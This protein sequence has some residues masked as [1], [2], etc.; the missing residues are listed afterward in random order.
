VSW[1]SAFG[2]NLNR[3]PI[4]SNRAPDTRRFCACWGK[5]AKGGV[6]RNALMRLFVAIDIDPVIR[7]RL[8]RFR[9]EMKPL[10]PQARWVGVETFHVTM[11]FIGEQSPQQMEN[12]QS[13]LS[14]I[15]AQ[16]VAIAFRNTGF[17]PAA[18]SA[19]VFWVGIE[20]D[21]NLALLAGHVDQALAALRIPREDRPFTP[22]LTLARGGSGR[23]QR[24]PADRPN[25]MF[26]SL[27]QRLSTTAPP[28]FGAMT[29][30][31]F[32]LYESKLS[33]AGAQY[34]KLARFPLG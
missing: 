10:A 12:I 26:A 27:Q 3:V 16:P 1:L 9:A 17:F 7:E 11:K 30:R 33:P 31:E 5:G 21:P 20:A 19:R 15:H 34:T 14:A 2:Q 25:A 32:F 22:H 8:A 18:R 13:A 28:D 23:P 24:Q 4:L 6:V 29:A